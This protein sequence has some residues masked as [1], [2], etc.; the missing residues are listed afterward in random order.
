VIS[1]FSD[2]NFN[3][4]MDIVP[5]I[6]GRHAPVGLPEYS[7]LFQ[8]IPFPSYLSEDVVDL[9][10]K[11]LDVNDATRLGAGGKKGLQDIKNHKFFSQIDWELLEQKHVEPPFIPENATKKLDEQSMFPTFE[12][13][14]ESFEKTSWLNEVVKE[15]DQKYFSTWYAIIRFCF[16]IFIVL[17][18][19]CLDRNFTSPHTLR[20]EVGLAN[21]MDQYD[22]NFKIRQIMGTNDSKSKG[23]VAAASLLKGPS[24]KFH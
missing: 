22:K 6:N 20:V 4:F 8:Q 7:I 17:V 9:I 10:T 21:E 11:L 3:E 24:M 2:E 23:K 5:T 14:M 12:A 13:M 1:P 18:T 15:E 19:L 16:P